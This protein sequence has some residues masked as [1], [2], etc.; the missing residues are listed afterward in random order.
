MTNKNN[1]LS[2]VKAIGIILM[3]IGHSGC[4]MP[5]H[6]IIYYFHMPLFFF[7][8]GYF[9]QM[10]G[11][12]ARQVVN[13]VKGLYLPYLKWSVPFLL[14]HNVFYAI[15]LYHTQYGYLGKGFSYYSFSDF[16]K[17][18]ASIVF[19]ME[20][21]EPLLGGFW[22]LKTLFLSSVLMILLSYIHTYIHTGQIQAKIYGC[23]FIDGLVAI[24][25]FLIQSSNN[26]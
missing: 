12:G 15:G 20:K 25:I 6:R 19:T 1:Y 3:V 24:K 11:G 21:H 8:S 23:I 4:P 10:K 17:R 2:T 18:L 16:W 26:W 5:L 14:L 22:F 9:F 7:V 13:K